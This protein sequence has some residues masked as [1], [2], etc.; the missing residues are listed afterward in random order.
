[1]FGHF[2]KGDMRLLLPLCFILMLFTSLVVDAQEATPT[3]TPGQA[4]SGTL[5]REGD[6]TAQVFTFEGSA[7]DVISLTA[8]SVDGLSVALLLTDAQGN[9]IAQARDVEGTGATQLAATLTD[10]GL[11]YVTVLP[12]VGVTSLGEGTYAL[13]LETNAEIGDGSDVT[14]EA[15]AVVPAPTEVPLTE[16]VPTETAPVQ[17]E[18]VPA[19]TEEAPTV[20]VTTS[21]MQ[22]TLGWN[23]AVDMDLEVRDP[24]GNTVYFDNP[25]V[26]FGGTFG[27]NVNGGCQA[28]VADNPT[29]EAGWS[30]GGVPTGSYEVLVYYQDACGTNNPVDFTVT[31]TVN[32]QQLTP[33]EG[34]LLEGQVYISSYEVAGNGAA[35]LSERRGVR[36]EEELPASAAVLIRS[37]QPLQLGTPLQGFIGNDQPF[38]AYS[39]DIQANSV[40]T[41]TMN[42]NSGSL[43]PYVILLD[44]NGNVIYFNDD[45]AEGVT[46]SSLTNSL[47]PVAGTYTVV[48]TRYGLSI[49]GTEGGYEL[50]VGGTQNLASTTPA[51]NTTPGATSVAQDVPPVVAALQL[52]E[53]SIEVTLVWNNASDLQLL[54]R[55]P[56]GD[57]VFDDIPAIR[58]GGRL[59]AA[60]NVNCSS[61]GNTPVSYIYWPPTVTPRAG[62]YELDVWFQNECNDTSAVNFTLY[63]SV[64]GQNVVTEAVTSSQTFLQGEHFVSSFTI[65][66]DGTVVAG[67]GG[68]T[69]INSLNWEAEAAQATPLTAGDSVNGS[70][71]LDNKFD[72]Y[73]FDGLSGDI[74]TVQMT[75]AAQT[76]LDTKLYLIGPDNTIVSQND[77]AVAG[78]NTDSLINNFTLPED[79]QYIIIATH[80][81][82]QYG[83]TSGAYTLTLEQ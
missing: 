74:V 71:T 54:V 23:A 31:V 13:I 34:T 11:Y 49:G 30:P 66:E 52:P 6:T 81:G 78:E 76:N 77:D 80:Y 24:V 35:T 36:G 8:T 57:S 27:P 5:T 38:Q 18:E 25:A 67:Q 58:S 69:G 73:S 21:G 3:L 59:G 83:V 53:G 1:M 82:E 15:T 41:I 37:A 39:F 56:A 28:L 19:Q 9:F 22:V 14:A 70:I 40:V 62:S 2:T 65:Q 51:A 16:V 50:S 79:G 17:T 72:L 45:A 4:T 29:E 26:D 47:L 46:D 32:G 44:P 64:N 33:V 12:I 61:T 42:A 63:V 48:A 20:F 10:D 7:G 43:D 60:G 55:D 75:A 68:I